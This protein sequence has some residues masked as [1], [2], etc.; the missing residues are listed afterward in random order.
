MRKETCNQG[1][2]V[3]FRGNDAW[4]DLWAPYD[5][6][7]YAAVCREVRPADVVLDIGAGDLRLT[8]RLARHARWVYAIEQQPAVL[9]RGLRAGSLPDNVCV[10]CGD[11]R[12]V[13]FPKDITLAVLLMR[14]CAHFPLYANKLLGTQCRRL[15]T[16]ARWRLD[17]EVVDLLA[18]RHSFSEVTI[19]WYACW[20]GAT[21]FVPGPPQALT[22]PVMA[23]VHEVWGCPACQAGPPG[24]A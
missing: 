13:V 11:A 7:T 8:Y 19:G 15:V 17:V 23:T 1:H 9:V 21:G 6:A 2:T 14:H 12:Q 22:K 18:P 20:C 5:E 24:S 10:I 16:N 4:E 3:A